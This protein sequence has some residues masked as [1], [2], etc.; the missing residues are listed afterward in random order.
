MGSVARKKRGDG[1]GSIYRTPQGWRG[2]VSLPGGSRRYV[3]G[4]TRAEVRDRMVAVH[5]ELAEGSILGD[6]TERLDGF[7]IWW[8]GTLE[9]RASSGRKSVNTVDNAAW[10]VSQWIIPNLGTKRLRDLGPED[11]EKLLALMA[12]KGKS[13]RTVGRV[14]TYL[15][16]ALSVAQ[17]RGYVNRN[18]ARLAEM[19]QTPRQAEKRTLTVEEAKAVLEAAEGHRLEA[20][21]V[22]AMMLGLRPGELLGMR[23]PDV[24]LTEGILC[25]SGSMKRERG[26]AKLGPTKTR[27]PRTVALPRAVAEALVIHQFRQNLERKEAARWEYPE[28]VFPTASGTPIEPSNLRRATKA[29]CEKAG[30]IPV[31]PNELGRHTAASLLYDNGLSLDQIADLLGHGSTRMLEQHY[32]HRV[33]EAVDSHVSTMDAVFGARAP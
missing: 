4:R 11:V 1:E 14:R 25:V 31:T 18:V 22:C 2:A 12:Q 8:L 5:T 16:Q 32:R 7:L 27:R 19:P 9:T 15:G 17:A 28:L 10:A 6:P 33:R 3:R 29:L 26:E 23:W 21:F 13:H 24:D 30:V 20:L